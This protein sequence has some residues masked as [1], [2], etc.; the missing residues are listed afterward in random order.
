MPL[1]SPSATE[2]PSFIDDSTDALHMGHWANDKSGSKKHSSRITNS[3]RYFGSMKVKLEHVKNP[4]IFIEIL[5]N[6]VIIQMSAVAVGIV[7]M[8]LIG[9]G[10]K[11]RAAAIAF[12]AKENIIMRFCFKHGFDAFF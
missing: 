3:M 11:V 6:A 12:G 10:K 5:K 7:D 8:L 1:L 9:A 2:L 4:E